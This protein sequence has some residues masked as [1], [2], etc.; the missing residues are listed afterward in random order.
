MA[1]ALQSTIPK[2]HRIVHLECESPHVCSL[3]V[4]GTMDARP[5]QFVM[6]WIPGMEEIPVSVSDDTGEEVH[7]TFFGVGETS[8]TLSKM[9]AGDLIGL[10]GP[11]GTHYEWE[12]GQRIVLVAGGYGAA[13]M[14][15][16]AKEVLKDDC[17]LDVLIGAQTKAEILFE[18]HIAKLG[19]DSIK[20]A[21]DDGT[22]GIKG[23]NTQLLEELIVEQGADSI[24]WI[25]ACGP[26]GMLKRVSEIAAQHDIPAQLSMH[27]YMKCGY[28]LCGNC[29]VDPLGIRMCVEGPVVHN[30][31][32]LQMTEF[33]KSHRNELGVVEG[34]K[35]S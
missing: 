12:K 32:A 8:K 9:Q 15:F 3:A 23:Y 27:R 35:K 24:D 20:F 25:F 21:T 14:Y 4:S 29:V 30:E 10:R 18:D 1:I 34:F 19:I 33:G 13:P 16:T 17:M 31:V 7:I 11:F 22:L 28:G 6:L 2:T 5:G 26:E